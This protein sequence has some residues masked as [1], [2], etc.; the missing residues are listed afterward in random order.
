M[1][2]RAAAAAGEP[3]GGNRQDHVR[4]RGAAAALQWVLSDLEEL[5]PGGDASGSA[6]LQHPLFAAV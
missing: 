2:S 5:R 6:A 3:F 1:V 4:D